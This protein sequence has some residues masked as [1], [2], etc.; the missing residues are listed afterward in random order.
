MFKVRVFHYVLQG[1][2]PV[3]IDPGDPAGH[4]RWAE[5]FKTADRHV[6]KET[7]GGIRI[8][9]V[10][11]GL[12]HG[13]DPDEAPILFESMCFA[14]VDEKDQ[15]KTITMPNGVIETYRITQEELSEFTE[16]YSTW[17][18]AEEGHR[19]IVTQIRKSLLKIVNGKGN[20]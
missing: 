3:A 18:E 12:D 10:F 1:K 7:I 5:W 13:F 19:R 16:R 11:L 2:T 6:A 17:Q 15:I 4:L 20:A 8:S 14:P 9:T